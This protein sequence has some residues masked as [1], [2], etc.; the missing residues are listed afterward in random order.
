MEV[1]IKVDGQESRGVDSFGTAY[2]VSAKRNELLVRREA[3][4]ERPYL[5]LVEATEDGKPLKMQA[6]SFWEGGRFTQKRQGWTFP[7][8]V[9]NVTLHFHSPKIVTTEFI[10]KASG[11]TSATAQ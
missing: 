4:L 5:I 7:K 3:G 11:P 8:S 1:S 6:S 2:F 9:T 10:A